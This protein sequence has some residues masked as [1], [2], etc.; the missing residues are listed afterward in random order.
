MKNFQTKERMLKGL[1]Q[2]CDHLFVEDLQYIVSQD[3]SEVPSASQHGEYRYCFGCCY[4]A[5]LLLRLSYP[6]ICHRQEHNLR[7]KLS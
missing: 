3:Q 1:N 7:L 6:T 5:L 2:Q 4:S